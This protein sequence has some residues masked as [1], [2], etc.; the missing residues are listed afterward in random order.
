MKA[1][2]WQSLEHVCTKMKG[3]TKMKDK[4]LHRIFVIGML[5]WMVG[6]CVSIFKM[7]EPNP[8]EVCSLTTGEMK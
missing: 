6:S 8:T 1:R 7:A 2:I 5:V 3:M 4:W